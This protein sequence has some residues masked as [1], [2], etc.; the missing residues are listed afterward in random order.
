MAR[1]NDSIG[2]ARLLCWAVMA[3]LGLCG[4]SGGAQDADTQSVGV[5]RTSEAL[6]SGIPIC[7]ASTLSSVGIWTACNDFTL[8][9]TV[10]DAAPDALSVIDREQVYELQLQA[11]ADGQF[12]GTVQ[13]E[14]FAETNEY[15]FYMNNSAVPFSV[16]ATD[17]GE[18]M[19]V[20]GKSVTTRAPAETGHACLQGSAPMRLAFV[21]QLKA[22]VNAFTL[23]FGPQARPMLTIVAVPQRTRVDTLTSRT[24]GVLGRPACVDGLPDGALCASVAST[25]PITAGD[26]GTSAPPTISEGVAYGVHLR[27]YQGQREG[28][29]QFHAA[30]EA[31]RY[32]VYLGTAKIGFSAYTNG[33]GVGLDQ[34]ERPLCANETD[35]SACSALRGIYEFQ[36]GENE[37]VRFE[38]TTPAN[39]T[40]EW[41]RLMIKEVPPIDTIDGLP[42]NNLIAWFKADAGVTLNTA[43]RV[44]NWRGVLQAG[45]L[46]GPGPINAFATTPER[47]P[48]LVVDGPN[49]KPW[50]HF[51]GG[52]SLAL[53]TLFSIGE[54]SI[55]F[56]GES[57]TANPN[58]SATVVSSG[59]AASPQSYVRWQGA[60]DLR[61]ELGTIRGGQLAWGS[62]RVPHLSAIEMGGGTLSLYR[63]AVFQGSL[64]GATGGATF[65]EIGS[66]GA[67]LMQGNLAELIIYARALSPA[68]LSTVQTYLLGKYAL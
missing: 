41:V 4:C 35:P 31:R 26:L 51:T 59:A 67:T 6:A 23:D 60:T 53:E 15:A 36:L 13:F 40:V 56:V 5:A 46:T 34:P 38:I 27:V 55:F 43:G 47:G 52:Q 12:S 45:V 48:L 14:P 19:P 10:L 37:D 8:R 54:F 29:L 11:Q 28:S 18:A 39:E 57:T 7:S 20:C 16:R 9:K 63:N 61:V 62:T 25:V 66:L 44:S 65:G 22:G 58:S 24:S 17:S 68:E 2:A 42:L 33:V 50:L 32:R 21:S 64:G 49:G 30:A 3:M 1:I